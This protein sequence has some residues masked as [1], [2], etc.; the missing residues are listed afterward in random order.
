MW[1]KYVTALATVFSALENY[2]TG[3]V[4]VCLAPPLHISLL[5]PP[6]TPVQLVVWLRPALSCC[7]WE[8]LLCDELCIIS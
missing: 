7:C 1:T 4:S 3:G 6:S 8:L 2:N 5:Y